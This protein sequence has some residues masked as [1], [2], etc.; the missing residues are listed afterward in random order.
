MMNTQSVA[1]SGRQQPRKN[2]CG[3]SEGDS[4]D[5]CQTIKVPLHHRGAADSAATHATAEHITHAATSSSVQ[6]HQEDQRQRNQKMDYSD[7]AVQ[8]DTNL[9]R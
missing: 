8:H 2:K 5:N 9:S 3:D 1:T 7:D 6:Q 4:E